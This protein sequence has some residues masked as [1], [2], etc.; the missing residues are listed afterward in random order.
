MEFIQLLQQ[1]KSLMGGGEF[2]D[3]TQQVNG[4]YL[5]ALAVQISY[6][7]GEVKDRTQQINGVY[8]IV[9]AVQISY[10]EG[11]RSRTTL[12]KLMEYIQSLQQRKSP[13]GR[14][15]VKDRTQQVN[16]V[17]PIASAA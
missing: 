8:P 1:C 6:G 10:G 17:Y 5:I 2:K 9:S 13:M 15:K 16:G 4:V 3:R 11:K 12:N 7:E 14:G